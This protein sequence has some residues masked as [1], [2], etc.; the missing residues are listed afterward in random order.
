M[1]LSSSVPRPS[2]RVLVSSGA[3]ALAAAAVAS[4]TPSALAQTDR[5]LLDMLFVLEQI[6][7]VH[8]AALLEAFNDEAFAAAGLP[9]DTRSGIERILQADSTH[10]ARLARPEGAPL[11]PPV[12]PSFTDLDA[13][14]RDA[15]VLKE[16]TGSAYAGVIPPIGRPGIIPDLIGMRSVEARHLTWLRGLLGEEPFPDDIDPTLAPADVLT[17]LAELSQSQ[18]AATPVPA[19]SAAPPALI[20]AIAT[21]LDVEVEDVQVLIVEPREWPDA[22]LGCPE[23]G[24]AYADVITP[25]YLIVVQ[26]GGAEYEFHTDE[27][28]AVVRCGSVGS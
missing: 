3:A 18:P 22:S 28:D 2:R 7:V 17:R 14:L 1:S 25:G 9:E 10:L 8:F 12:S 13:A 16:L 11:P 23:P 6:E 26:A 27:R 21:E 24:H 5:A 15:I 19:S 4:H 20:A